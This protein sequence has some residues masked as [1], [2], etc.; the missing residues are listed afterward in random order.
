MKSEFKSSFAENIFKHKYALTQAQTWREKC[1]S[2][3]E[4]VCG[5]G[6][7]GKQPPLLSKDDQHYLTEALVQFKWMPGGRYIYYAGRPARFWNNCYGLAGLEDSR[8]EWANLTQR[9]LSCLMTGGGIGVDYSV[10]RSKGR[11]L[12][13]TGGAASGPLPLAMIINEVG[14]NVCQGGSRRSAI[15]GSLNWQHDDINEFLVAKNWYDQPIGKAGYTVA[16]AKMDDFNY[17]APLDMTNISVNYDDAWLARVQRG[18][19]PEVYLANVRQALKTGEPGFSFNF[20]AQEKYTIRN[21]PVCAETMV[22]TDEGYR[23]VFELIDKPS[24]VWTGKQWAKDV[25]FRKTGED[26]PTLIVEMTGGRTIHCDPSHPFFVETYRWVSGRGKEITIKRVAASDLKPEDQIHVSLPEVSKSELDKKAY[27]LGFLYGDGHFSVSNS[28]ASVSICCP[29]KEVCREGLYYPLVSSIN[30]SDNRGY[31]RIYFS[32]NEFFSN[33]YKDFFPRE[34]YVASVDEKASFVAGLFDADG[35]YTPKTKAIRLSCSHYDFLIGVRRVLESIGILSHICTGT[36]KSGYGGRPSFTLKITA[37]HVNRFSEMIP[38]FRIKAEPHKSYR[39]AYVKVINV[40]EASREDVY[41]ADVGVEEHSFMAEGVILSNC[42]EFITDTDSDVCNLASLNLGGIE[43]LDEFKQLTNTVSK[44]LIC[45]SVRSQL[46]YQKAYD[47]RSANRRIGLGLMGIHEWLLQRNYG[48]EVVPELHEWLSAYQHESES[49]ANEHCDR[50]YLNRPKAYRAVAPTGTIAILAGTTTGIEPLFATAYKR[51]YLVESNHWR[52]EYVVDSVAEL[53]I[54][55]YGFD[56]DTIETAA[57]LAS[58]PE[59]R[60]KFQFDV[61]SYCDM[62]VSSTINLPSWGSELNNEDK[63]SDFSKLIAKYA[64]G[65]R[66]LTFYPD[67]SRGGQ[68]ITPVSYQEA[69]AQRGVVFEENS[70][71]KDGACGI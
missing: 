60:L 37:D 44:F 50:F 34:L 33:R 24:V 45:G 40:T 18:E 6:T 8:E 67:G 11:I 16:D 5:V 29:E 54:K 58:N 46:P 49:G 1:R 3:I 71:C 7:N 70:A 39:P 47:V 4:S 14:R 41:C 2:I 57:S 69:M 59:K 28:N 32:K 51:R 26:S 63:V 22:M 19:L 23:A 35:N 27:T 10:F 62:G 42:T 36:I 31:T 20:G 25:V 48:Y 30:E 66:G 38:C 68:P 65:L 52:C 55:Q 21:A 12:S 17:P 61:Q 15:Y 64:H 9:A 13:K 43:T 56:P 53:L